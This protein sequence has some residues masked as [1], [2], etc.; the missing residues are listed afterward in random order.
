MYAADRIG[1]F[2]RK[3]LV[4]LALVLY[5]SVP[6]MYLGAIADGNIHGKCKHS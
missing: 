6:F 1:E 3:G 4:Y 5:Y 2:T